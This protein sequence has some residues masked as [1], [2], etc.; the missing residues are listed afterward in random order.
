MTLD[1]ATLDLSAALVRALSRDGRMVVTAESCTGGLVSASLTHHAGSSSALCGGFVTY[2]NAMKQAVL[3]VPEETLM[4]HGAVSAETARAMARGALARA[5]EA[6]IAVAVSGVAG[7]GGG[8]P[9]KP[10]GL[11]WFAV[12]WTDGSGT[13]VRAEHHVFGGDRAAVRDQS[14]R[15]ALGLIEQARRSLQ[16]A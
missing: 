1:P 3:G 15:V 16:A 14:V 4:R 13:D 11:V 12:A 9:D 5:P 8:T 7:P 2:S 6:S 10:V